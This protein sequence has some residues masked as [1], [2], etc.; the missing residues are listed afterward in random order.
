[1]RDGEWEWLTDR[2]FL[3]ENIE[4]LQDASKHFKIPW[5]VDLDSRQNSI[6]YFKIFFRI[7]LHSL[8]YC[9]IML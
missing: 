8:G 4:G 9:R 3:I 1:V 5:N 7:L 2:G 6:K